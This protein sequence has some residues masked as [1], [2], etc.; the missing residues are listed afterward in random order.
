MRRRTVWAQ[1]VFVDPVADIAVLSEPDGQELFNEHEAYEAL[2]ASVEP[3][4][5]GTLSFVQQE[6][7]LPNG[8][9]IAREAE[10]TCART[11]SANRRQPLLGRCCR[12]IGG[13][14]PVW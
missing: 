9:I 13:G 4:L 7:R 6:R 1:C 3:F 5:L 11:P 14:S 8:N 2:T 12:S 10:L